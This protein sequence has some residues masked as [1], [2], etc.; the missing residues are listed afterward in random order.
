MAALGITDQFTVQNTVDS[1][2]DSMET[3]QDNAQS[4]GILVAVGAKES[5]AVFVAVIPPEG[6]DSDCVSWHQVNGPL[7]GTL[8]W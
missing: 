2:Q 5:S 8:G 3:D 7:T 4:R 6:V 1:G